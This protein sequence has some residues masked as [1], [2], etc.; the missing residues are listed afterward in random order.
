MA[1]SSGYF[2]DRTIAGLGAELRSGAVTAA[3]LA[4][5]A[6]DAIA[7]RDGELN[8]FVSVD[9]EAALQAAEKADAELAEG[10]D[11]GPLHGIPVG[12][13]DVIDVAGLPTTM[14]SAHFAGHVSTEDA[15]CVRRLRAGGAV[16]V[17]KTTTHEFAY[18]PTGDS[19]H[20][21]PCRNPHDPRL[22]S[23]GSSAG[24]AVAVASGMVPLAVGTD[25]G[26]SAR[27]PAALCGVAGFKPAY[28]AIPADGVFPLAE[29]LDHIGVLARTAQD[30]RTAYRVLADLRAEPGRAEP[31]AV[32]GWIRPGALC[33]T[34]P[35]VER[36]AR[37]AV[38][39]LDVREM[40]LADP[41]LPLSAYSGIQDG[42]VFAVHAERVQQ[43]PELYTPAVLERLR[44]AERTPAWRHVRAQAA[45]RRWRAEV[46]ALLSEVDL[47]ALPTTCVVAAPVGTGTVEV[48]GARVPVNRALLSLTSPWSVAGVPAISVPAGVL[49][50]LPVGLQLVCRPGREDLLF[51]VAARLA[52]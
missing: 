46:D 38:E 10:T 15:E 23:G 30:C 22:M 43:R 51:A 41:D 13:K 49:G 36:I 44:G 45:R 9:R 34:D 17:G 27:I 29:S 1:D 40:A 39:P 28:R 52:R 5:A 16:V 6:L 25:T 8:A 11:R 2:T 12:V 31:E 14:G 4:R 18:G 24:S 33:P 35:E 47:L 37:A 48:D 26:G 7:D 50:H 32:V 20:N 19:A 21:G 42:E 3:G